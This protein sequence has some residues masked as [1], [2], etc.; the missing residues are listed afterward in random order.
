MNLRQLRTITA[1]LETQSFAAAGGTVGLSPS[2]VSIQMKELEAHLGAQLFDRS[3]RPPTLT[4]E[5]IAVANAARKALAEIEKIRIAAS[6]EELPA[7]ISIGFVPTNLQEILPRFLTDFRNAFPSIQLLIKS[8]LS[9]ELANKVLAREIDFA[10][11]TSPRIAH[12]ELEVT[13]IAEEPTYVIGPKSLA[14]IETDR[15]RLLALPYI[16]FNKRAWLGQRVAAR[17]Q[18]R[19]INVHEEMELD[20]LDAMER[21]VAYGHGVS[22]VPQRLLA[23]PLEQNLSTIPFCT[24]SLVRQ[25]VLIQNRRGR[26]SEVDLRIVEILRAIGQQTWRKKLSHDLNS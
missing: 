4:A 18:S 13:S 24:P 2:A 5:G 3:S 6:G 16:A 15:E 19:G 14:N 11:V 23:P 17:L 10:L 26:R 21:L 8:G 25:L 9:G 22:I 20:A 1:F 12:E 7:Q